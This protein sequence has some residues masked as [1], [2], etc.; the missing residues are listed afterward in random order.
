YYNDEIELYFGQTTLTGVGL[1]SGRK[2]N[3]QALVIAIGNLPNIHLAKDCGLEYKRGVVVNNHLQTKDP[4]VFAV[5]EIAEIDGTVFNFPAAAEEQAKI[6]AEFIHGNINS[7]YK[8]S[9]L[10]NKIR[11]QGFHVCSVGLTECPNDEEY[12]EVVWIDKRKRFYKK[13]IIHQDKL[14]GAILIGENTEFD[15]FSD[16]IESQKP[17]GERRFQLFGTVTH[18]NNIVQDSYQKKK[19]QH[20]LQS[21]QKIRSNFPT[22]AVSAEN[23]FAVNLQEGKDDEVYN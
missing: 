9:L 15:Y 4:S 8:G 14:V 22:P 23:R 16:L 2:I 13:C 10:K 19:K 3:C 12:E 18:F 21:K 17:L 1:K 20:L 5:G 6:V 11:L 7:F